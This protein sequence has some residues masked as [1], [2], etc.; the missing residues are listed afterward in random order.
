MN[1]LLLYLVSILLMTYGLAFMIIYINL[2]AFGY[3]FINYLEFIFT[4]FDCLLFFV[5]L[6]IML[7]LIFRKK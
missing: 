2:F 1:R 5:G 3:S 6:L 7:I 4:S